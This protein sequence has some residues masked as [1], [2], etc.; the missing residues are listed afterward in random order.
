MPMAQAVTAADT[1]GHDA[2]AAADVDATPQAMLEER[3]HLWHDFGK[4]LLANIIAI[5]V[6]LIGMAI[7]LV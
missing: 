1:H 4:F 5:A 6:V 2:H 3:R 7:F